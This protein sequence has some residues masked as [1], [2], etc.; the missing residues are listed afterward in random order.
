MTTWLHPATNEATQ[1]TIQRPLA[2]L[3]RSA[4]GCGRASSPQN[5]PK[6][7]IF[8]KIPTFFRIM[9]PTFR[10]YRW[11]AST[12]QDLQHS[13]FWRVA[14]KARSGS[15]YASCS[16][17]IISCPTK[18]LDQVACGC[19]LAWCVDW[20]RNNMTNTLL[21]DIR[22]GLWTPRRAGFS[23]FTHTRT[24]RCFCFVKQFAR[25]HG[26]HFKP[27]MENQLKL[28]QTRLTVSA[29][30]E[31]PER[32]AHSTHS[33]EV[34]DSIESEPMPSW[35]LYDPIGP[36]VYC[37]HFVPSCHPRNLSDILWYFRMHDLSVQYGWNL[38]HCFLPTSLTLNC[39][40]YRG[41][42]REFLILT[43]TYELWLKI[44]SQNAAAS[45][46][47]VILS[48]FRNYCWHTCLLQN[49]SW[50]GTLLRTYSNY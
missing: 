37:F 26:K 7:Y 16:Q 5:R 38:W 34:L 36:I 3:G 18:K 12:M 17:I 9:L 45:P 2:W 43:P 48:H 31:W 47:L 22:I 11:Y 33:S 39:K 20:K 35:I 40:M 13:A 32:G 19:L 46:S 10:S 41:V 50:T 6:R 23:A 4:P 14:L 30:A 25:S 27:H 42:L 24:S 29:L 15:K 8:M 21:N 44:R 28:I 1:R 49:H